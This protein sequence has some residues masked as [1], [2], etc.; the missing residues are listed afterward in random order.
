M[1]A[2]NSSQPSL[3]RGVIGFVVGGVVASMASALVC[4]AFFPLP[5]EPNPRNHTGEALMVLC[6]VMFPCGGMIGRQGFSVEFWSDLFPSVGRSFVASLLLCLVA[7]LGLQETASMMG[8]ASV[9]IVASAA[10]SLLL[11]RCFPAK[12]E[13]YEA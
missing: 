10:A 6:I 2:V 9:G 5:P 11:G 13:S 1:R 3:L 12:T 8:F 7:R 4:L